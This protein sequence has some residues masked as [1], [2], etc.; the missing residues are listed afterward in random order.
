MKSIDHAREFANPNNRQRRTVM[1]VDMNDSTLM[2]QSTDEV[3][4]RAAC[5]YL[6]DTVFKEHLPLASTAKVNSSGGET[7]IEFPV[8]KYLGDGVMAVFAER[9]PEEVLNVAIRI[10]NQIDLLGRKKIVKFTC[11]IGIAHGEVVEWMSAFG[12]DYIGS[13]VDKA[14]RLQSEAPPGAIWIDDS[15]FQAGNMET[16][17]AGTSEFEHTPLRTFVGPERNVELRG[18]KEPVKY[19]EVRWKPASDDTAPASAGALSATGV[20]A[21]MPEVGT[22]SVRQ[23]LKDTGHGFIIS[24]YQAFYY[25]DRRFLA[26]GGDLEPGQRVFFLIREPLVPGKNRVA[27]CVV[28]FGGT[29]SGRVSRVTD[30]GYGFVQIVDSM[31]NLWSMFLYLGD[32]SAGIE[33]GDEVRFEIGEND[34]GPCGKDARTDVQ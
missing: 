17:A 3:Y 7:P 21:A 22:G 15:T 31:G 28:R 4:W 1:F 32:N 23:W 11:S 9:G 24:P 18:F 10:H 12:P 25:T 19:H 6:F 29:Y 34:R 26:D 8:T 2:K 13:L 16:P 33:V 20:R 27:A 30:K 14:A 5:A